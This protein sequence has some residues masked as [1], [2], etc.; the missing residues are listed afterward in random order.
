MKSATLTL[1]FKAVVAFLAFT[2]TLSAGSHTIG[3]RAPLEVQVS[4]VKP[5]VLDF[6]FVISSAKL[7]LSDEDA[8]AIEVLDRGVLIIPRKTH[9]AGTIVLTAKDGRNY[10]VN[11][12]GDG[13]ETMQHIEDPAQEY[14]AM[15]NE[16]LT[17]ET[18]QIDADARNIVKAILLQKPISGYK[19]IESPKRIRTS[20]FEMVRDHRYVGG[21]YVADYW[22]IQNS[23]NEVKYFKESEFYTKGVLAV[24]LQK[25]RV[26][27]GERIYLL[28][29]LNKVSIYKQATGG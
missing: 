29:L 10:V 25:Y 22:Q 18:D 12:A 4:G 6:N 7:I 24:G 5:S 3:Q 15:Q 9:P 27:P 23:S 21:K 17:F 28:L 19:K 2:L 8:A 16:K 1:T 14:D 11:F 26:E 20:E 13:N